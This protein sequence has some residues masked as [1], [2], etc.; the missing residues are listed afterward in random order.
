MKEVRPACSAAGLFFTIAH[1]AV[2]SVC[3][4]ADC[5]LSDAEVKAMS[6]VLVLAGSETSATALSG[7][8]FLISLPENADKLA[9]LVDEVR[10]AFA[11]EA[12]MNIKST[13]Q[14]E[15]LKAAIDET[16]RMYPPAVTL[17]PR[18]SP[19][20]AVGGH[21]L[22]QGVSIPSHFSFSAISCIPKYSSC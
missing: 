8:V 15:Y 1:A 18:V 13:A 17:T 22:P 6:S 7:F 21:W 4:D 16:M 11:D 12:D 5:V 2:A 20:A 9:I 19:G 3:F 14:L 10:S